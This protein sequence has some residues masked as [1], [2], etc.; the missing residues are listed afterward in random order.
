M[1]E[2]GIV[3]GVPGAEPYLELGASGQGRVFRKHLITLNKQFLH[4][5][6]GQPITLG[7]DAWQQMK[8][9]FDRKRIIQ[10]PVFT[11]ADENN[12]HTENPLAVAG[13]VTALE[14]DGDR[15]IATIDVKDPA[16]AERIADGRL[17]GA[18]AFLALDSK[19]PA[20]G[21][22]AGAA[23]LHICG[24]L[25]PALVDLEPYESAV[26]ACE[27][28][29]TA[30]PD[31]SVWP[32]TAL[33][34]CQSEIGPAPVMLAEP[35]YPPEPAYGG[36]DMH[37]EF[38][39]DELARLGLDAMQLS[40]GQPSRPSYDHVKLEQEQ[41]ERHPDRVQM[42][43]VDAIRAVLPADRITRTDAEVCSAFALQLAARPELAARAGR[44]VSLTTIMT[45]ARQGAFEKD[46][47]TAN[48]PEALAV[49]LIGM[50]NELGG[51]DD[52]ASLALT[53]E[54][55]SDRIIGLAHPSK[56]D[57]LVTTGG[58]NKRA[59]EP[60]GESSTRDDP[61]TAYA[62]WR[63][64]CPELFAAEDEDAGAHGTH[65]YG[66]KTPAQRHLEETY[67][68]DGG[69]PGGRS[70]PELHPSHAPGHRQSGSVRA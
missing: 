32:P 28:A 29:W 69:R 52:P 25:R 15:V 16:V 53:V 7:E 57:E 67:A 46:E 21:E 31:G 22:R 36:P 63:K 41:R 14:R 66:P 5:K 4:P 54:A 38:L 18:S 68:L 61:D 2:I 59:H 9:S 49:E 3:P 8:D 56:S 40:S 42:S 17:P 65:S 45:A 43:A 27:P 60:A 23:L 51:A 33:M 6:T 24:T 47:A 26:A 13:L 12:R 20:T 48:E 34:L 30:L 10:Q 1:S 44:Q 55:E 19:D 62:R 35:E 58:K 37:D 64:L 39:A 11:L 70:I 50:S